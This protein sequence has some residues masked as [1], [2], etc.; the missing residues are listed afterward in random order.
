MA[1]GKTARKYQTY[2]YMPNLELDDT[3]S[4]ELRRDE[5][6]KPEC[7]TINLEFGLTAPSNLI[8]IIESLL[9]K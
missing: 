7:C 1:E 5:N 9:R 4:N 6:Q 3:K 8:I 2:F